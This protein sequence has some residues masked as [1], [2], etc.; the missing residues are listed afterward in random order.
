VSLAEIIGQPRALEAVRFGVRIRREGYN[1]FAMG[2]HGIGKQTA[3]TQFL[4]QQA[5]G[6]P[7]PV[8]WCYVYNFA[9]P[10]Q[11]RAL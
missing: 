3:V 7:T 10:H 11:L 6:E 8:D 9:Q 5:V 1:L 4:T 2:P